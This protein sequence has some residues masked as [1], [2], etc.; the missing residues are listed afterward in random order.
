MKRIHLCHLAA[1]LILLQDGAIA[2]NNSIV[3]V[4]S[5][6]PI[7]KS[8]VSELIMGYEIRIRGSGAS[9]A[10]IDA[11]LKT[12]REKALQTLVDQELILKEFEPFAAA[13]DAKVDAYTK[14]T[15]RKNI[16]DG[17]F[18]GDSQQFFR[19]LK[20]SGISYQK[21]Y[22]LQRKNV[23]V[24]M[25]RGQFARTDKPYITNEEVAAYLNKHEA[26]FRIGGKI[27]LWSITIPGRADGKT[28]VQQLALAREVRAS[29]VN[30]A[31]FS[32]L[33][34]T[35]SAD[36]KRESGGSW[37]WVDKSTIAT[38]FWPVVSQLATGKVSEILPMGGDYYIFWV[39]ARMPGRMK[40][41]GEVDAEVETRVQIE[42]RQKAADEWV[43][44]LR[45]KATI[46]FFP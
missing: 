27:K 24:E 29:L 5:G 23:I 8:E 11:Q 25:M 6:R 16:I 44:K 35:H 12:L 21:F 22:A 1:V 46:K 9:P 30:G 15:I 18:K 19:E 10:E 33:A 31:D 37:G 20:E 41:K 7:L 42:K 43:A 14:Q 4:V 39:E 32:S 2:A 36:S 17:Q 3:A 13:F 40:P 34:R 45:R 28:G 38:P 26:A